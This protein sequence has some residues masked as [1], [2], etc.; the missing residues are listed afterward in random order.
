MLRLLNV[1]KY[2]G[3]AVGTA[4]VSRSVCITVLQYVI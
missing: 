4:V 1:G 2:Y 3:T